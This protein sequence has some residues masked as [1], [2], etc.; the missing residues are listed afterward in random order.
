MAIPGS[1][2]ASMPFGPCAGA[3]DGAS[4]NHGPGAGPTTE[5]KDWEAA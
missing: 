2:R 1:G 4:C 3:A 5:S